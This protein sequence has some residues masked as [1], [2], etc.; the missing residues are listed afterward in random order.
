MGCSTVSAL[1]GP[2]TSVV[3]VLHR[4]D[5][6]GLDFQECEEAGWRQR[7]AGTRLLCTLP[8]LADPAAELQVHEGAGCRRSGGSRRPALAPA[9]GPLHHR[10]WPSPVDPEQLP[11]RPRPALRPFPTVPCPRPAWLSVE[12]TF[13]QH[14]K[15]GAVYAPSKGRGEPGAG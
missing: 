15:G 13:G 10:G 9:R 12:Q 2:A 6:T 14:Q 11:A 7:L 1:A 5:G 8:L 3:R 4:P